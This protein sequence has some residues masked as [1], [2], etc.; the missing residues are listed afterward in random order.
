MRRVASAAFVDGFHVGSW[1]AGAVALL[2]VTAALVWLPARAQAEHLEV[3]DPE[4]ELL[5]AR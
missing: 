4:P 3:G 5:V 1:V 2:G